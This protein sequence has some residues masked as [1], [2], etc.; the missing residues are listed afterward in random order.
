MP[1]NTLRRAVHFPFDQEEM[2]DK[3][4]PPN[5]ASKLAVYGIIADL[6]DRK[7]ISH[8]LDVI[9]MD[10]RKEIVRRCCIRV[11][12]NADPVRA[13]RGVIHELR[14]YGSVDNEFDSL[15][16]DIFNELI[17]QNAEIVTVARRVFRT[18]ELDE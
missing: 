1:L 14:M 5:S 15:D 4:T 3:A 16:D 10:E 7:G 2:V 12:I 17:V 18:G 11:D 13:V 6:S 8:G 9:D